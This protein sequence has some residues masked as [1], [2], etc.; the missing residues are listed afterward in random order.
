MSRRESQNA[1]QVE[2]QEKERR[3]MRKRH[4]EMTQNTGREKA[5]L[6]ERQI[7]QRRRLFALEVH[8]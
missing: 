5:Y 8:Q 2:R 1:L 6:K 7:E 3:R 4:E